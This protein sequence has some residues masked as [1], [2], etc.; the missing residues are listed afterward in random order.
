[1]CSPK[2]GVGCSVYDIYAQFGSMYYFMLVPSFEGESWHRAVANLKSRLDCKEAISAKQQTCGPPSRHRPTGNC[3]D[4][5]SR[6]NSTS[7]TGKKAKLRKEPRVVDTPRERGNS[8]SDDGFWAQ[9]HRLGALLDHPRST[10]YSNPPEA[11]TTRM[12]HGFVPNY[13]IGFCSGKHIRACPSSSSR[14]HHTMTQQGIS[15]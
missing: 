15:Q 7:K 4:E 13:N 12:T 14:L 10:M 8:R 5:S 2:D 11:N 6:M 1:M 3:V 9:D